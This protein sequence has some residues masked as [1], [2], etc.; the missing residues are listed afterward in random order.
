MPQYERARNTIRHCSDPKNNKLE[1][2]YTGIA[3]NWWQKQEKKDSI[4]SL[5]CAIFILAIPSCRFIKKQ[6]TAKEDNSHLA[7]LF[8]SSRLFKSNFSLHFSWT[9][10][11]AVQIFFALLSFFFF[12]FQISLLFFLLSF[13]FSGAKLLEFQLT[14][15]SSLLFL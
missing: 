12:F 11:S 5:I 14:H 4:T 10:L 1:A 6:R 8:L 7:F 2:N 9:E 15:I 3:Q 13:P